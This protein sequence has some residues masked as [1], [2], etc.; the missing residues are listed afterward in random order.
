MNPRSVAPG[1]VGVVGSLLGAIAAAVSTHDYAQ[2]LDRKLHGAHCSFIPGAGE[3][4]TDNACTAAM[5]SPYS[6][7]LK[8][9]YWGGIPISLFGLGAFAFTFAVALYLILA[10][11]SAP[12]RTRLAYFLLTLAPF[13]AS[14]VMFVISATKLGQFCKVCV[15]MYT[16]SVILF[17]SGVLALVSSRRPFAAVPPLTPPPKPPRNADPSAPADKTEVDSEPW[18]QKAEKKAPTEKTVHVMPVGSWAAPIGLLA[19]MGTATALPAAVYAASLP[20][21][22]DRILACGKLEKPAA[23][24][25]VGRLRDRLLERAT[26]KSLRRL[27][28]RRS[29]PRIRPSPR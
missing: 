27:G 2:N 25:G 3:A 16:A 15:A 11:E 14:I 8:D 24:E 23:P 13:G 21:Y 7:L 28:Q 17:V 1:I 9:R 4:T 10:R 18:H 26:T 5:Q 6:A 22:D 29:P 20:S 19:A 12:Q